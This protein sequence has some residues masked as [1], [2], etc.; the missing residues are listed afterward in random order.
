MMRFVRGMRGFQ[1]G[2]GTVRD[3]TPEDV[4]R[5][6]A[7]LDWRP[8]SCEESLLALYCYVES[9]GRDNANWYRRKK[10]PRQVFSL[11][12]R[13]LSLIFALAGGLCPL[14]PSNS[15]FPDAQR[16]GYLLLGVGGG[17][18]LFDRLFGIS[19]AWM[20]YMLAALEIEASM[21]SFNVQWIKAR[22]AASTAGGTTNL[23]P[24]FMLA[25]DALARIDGIVQ[26]ETAE[27]QGEFQASMV[28]LAH[29]GN[30]KTA[31]PSHER[32]RP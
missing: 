8:E 17:L 11:W 25:T 5:S 26:R 14:L 15:P 18:F 28:H 22:A 30:L 23:E 13:L 2:G 27:W 19:S 29:L 7:A 10:A 12:I 16:Y 32:P 21:H 6:F 20:R 9:I 24:F 1:S 4:G 31:S 3:A